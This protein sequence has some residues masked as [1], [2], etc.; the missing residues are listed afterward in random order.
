MNYN[1]RL[2]YQNV[3]YRCKHGYCISLST[4]HA[5]EICHIP[6]NKM[7]LRAKEAVLEAT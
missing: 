4:V 3:E 1:T 7:R 2:K 6:N 5:N